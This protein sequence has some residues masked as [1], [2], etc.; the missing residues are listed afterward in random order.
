MQLIFVNEP[1]TV[2]M[3]KL[4]YAWRIA[5]LL[6]FLVM[7]VS[8]QDITVT[9]N[10]SDLEKGSALESVSIRVV[11]KTVATKT[12]ARGNFTIKA[13][14]GQ[15]LLITSLGYESQRVSVKD[16]QKNNSTLKSGIF[17]IRRCCGCCNGPEKKASL[18]WVIQPNK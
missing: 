11:G 2:V 12:D 8:A 3:R 4:A 7:K 18:N 17:R 15:T 14:K 9:G 6:F 16:D 13:A 10:V 5:F 1:N